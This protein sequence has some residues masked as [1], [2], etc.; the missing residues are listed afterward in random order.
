MGKASARPIRL[1]PVPDWVSAKTQI[2]TI[3][4]WHQGAIRL[5]NCPA[6]R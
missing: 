3:V 5:R 1:T 6:R 4:R 2:K